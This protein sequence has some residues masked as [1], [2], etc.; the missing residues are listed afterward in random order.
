[1]FDIVLPRTISQPTHTYCT[2]TT[3][4]LGMLK[5][6]FLCNLRGAEK[7]NSISLLKKYILIISL[8]IILWDMR[9]LKTQMF[10]N[11]FLYSYVI[12]HLQGYSHAKR[13]CIL[14]LLYLAVTDWLVYWLSA[15]LIKT[16][17]FNMWLCPL[18]INLFFFYVLV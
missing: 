6:S 10:H 15:Y 7:S 8:L 4:A 13:I 14:H 18:F 16:M 2:P 11:L 3:C 1:M 5:I 12:A 17:Q 9:L